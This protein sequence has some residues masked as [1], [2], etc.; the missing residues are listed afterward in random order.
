LKITSETGM[1]LDSELGLA[2]NLNDYIKT[3]KLKNAKV[4]VVNDME[5][6]LLVVNN[7]PI[8]EN[9]SSESIA[10]KID[11]LAFLQNQ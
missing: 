7:E 3:K 11:L 1:I 5:T 9:T 10:V 2:P 8:Y 6:Y 4:F